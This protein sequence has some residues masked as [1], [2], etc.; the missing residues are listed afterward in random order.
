MNSELVFHMPP[1]SLHHHHI[2]MLHHTVSMLR[3]TT[4]CTVV[5]QRETINRVGELQAA[6]NVDAETQAKLLLQHG[7]DR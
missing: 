2:S 7:Q 1:A 4:L 5:R 6:R 3:T